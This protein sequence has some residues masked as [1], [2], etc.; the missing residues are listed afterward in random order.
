MEE[1]LSSFELQFKRITHISDPFQSIQLSIQKT[2]LLH[3]LRQVT[4]PSFEM[5]MHSNQRYCKFC[6][7]KQVTKRASSVANWPPSL[8]V[9]LKRTG[10]RQDGTTFKIPTAVDI[11][12]TLCIKPSNTTV[13]H[14]YF[15]NSIICH[16]GPHAHH[17]HYI[18]YLRIA[19]NKWLCADDTVPSICKWQ[20]ILPKIKTDAYICSYSK[21][22][23]FNN[24]SITNSASRQPHHSTHSTPSTQHQPLPTRPHSCDWS[25]KR[26][27]HARRSRFLPKKPSFPSPYLNQH[28]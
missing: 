4:H 18:C 27:K 17:G 23:P 3:L 14:Q 8:N 19:E 15:L 2:S 7:R 16:S 25:T 26:S 11:P 12:L 1:L 10:R 6:K 9:T 24:T 13:Q 20:S 22:Y 5:L 21:R 28:V